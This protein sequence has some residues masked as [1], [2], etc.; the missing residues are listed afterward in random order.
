M[1]FLKKF[2]QK[3]QLLPA[4]TEEELCATCKS[5]FDLKLCRRA[6]YVQCGHIACLN[7]VCSAKSGCTQC[8]LPV[9][10][11]KEECPVKSS[12][13]VLSSALSP[14]LDDDE[15]P[16]IKQL[17]LSVLPI[18]DC[19]V[20]NCEVNDEDETES[21]PQNVPKLEVS[22]DVLLPRYIPVVDL[23]DGEAI[24]V[25]DLTKDEEDLEIDVIEIEMEHNEI[26]TDIT[27]PA[28]DM[29]T[30][31]ECNQIETSHVPA[32][33][34][35]EKIIETRSEAPVADVDEGYSTSSSVHEQRS[36]RRKRSCR[37]TADPDIDGAPG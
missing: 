12:V 15:F 37:T 11:I 31:L 13:L 28:V 33:V 30:D 17:T 24:P 10:H 25:V 19:P 2:G 7:C 14:C 4:Q 21:L 32:V 20:E 8:P 26:Q 27:T 9:A 16:K 22:P 1:R 18:L 6:C 36:L 23:C 34:L 29:E 5:P 3:I 35:P